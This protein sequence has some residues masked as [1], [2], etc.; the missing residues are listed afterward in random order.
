MLHYNRIKSIR[1][2]CICLALFATVS[3]KQE[4]KEPIEKELTMKTKKKEVIY[5]VFTRL[6]GNTNTTNKPWG[7]M[8]ENEERR[9]QMM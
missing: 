1:I 3:C 6:F 7:T 8:E 2:A 5:Q 4:D 9:S